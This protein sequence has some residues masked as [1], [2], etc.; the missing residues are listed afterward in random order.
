MESGANLELIEPY[1]EGVF[2]DVRKVNGLNVVSPV[3]LYLDLSSRPGRGA[4]AAEF[5]LDQVLKRKRDRE[6]CLSKAGFSIRV[7]A[8]TDVSYIR[9]TGG[10]LHE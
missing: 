10:H 5:L 4:E 9:E 3:Q 8:V 2:Y 1:D 7:A 6:T